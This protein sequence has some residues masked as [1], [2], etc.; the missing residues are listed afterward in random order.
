[1]TNENEQN[2]ARKG[3]DPNRMNDKLKSSLQK[4]KNSNQ[5]T[6]HNKETLLDF[7]DYL[8]RVE[9]ISVG[10]VE[11]PL[12]IW[13]ILLTRTEK[14]F[15]MDEPSKED[16]VRLKN[17]IMDNE[18]KDVKTG[19]K[20]EYLKAVNKFYNHYMEYKHKDFNGDKYTGFYKLPVVKDDQKTDPDVLPRPHH[21]QE[22]VEN[23]PNLRDKTLI[24]CLW[25]T[26]ARREEVLNIKW[27]HVKLREDGGK[28][29]IQEKD[30]DDSKR[31]VPLYEG[32]LYLQRLRE[33]DKMGGDPES[34]VF[35]STKTNEQLSCNG[36][37]EAI[38]RARRRS[39]LPEEKENLRTNPHAFRKGRAV[40]LAKKGFTYT[41]LC[42]LQGWEIGSDIPKRYIR[43]AEGDID[44]RVRDKSRNFESEDEELGEGFY[45]EPLR[46]HECHHFNRWE[47]DNCESC[48]QVLT[49]SEI[50]EHTQIEDM[51]D[52]LVY[53][54]ARSEAGIQ[55]EEIKEKAKE[56]VKERQEVEA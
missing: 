26:G 34:Y 45:F 12:T 44:S 54:V 50:F 31:T 20:R 11:R 56:L 39:E 32:Y 3:G 37:C 4:I 52:E 49:E 30:E 43:I 10:R 51:T 8:D 41:D 2:S 14:Q 6:D 24:M 17:E 5:L 7:Y 13:R 25:S 38:K 29:K 9:D 33:E 18:I 36:L 27:K 28:V 35:R 42:Q 47:A 22:L 1:M 19:T 46:C 23:A 53:E 21:V 15:K 40:Y 16:I 48:G 55:Q